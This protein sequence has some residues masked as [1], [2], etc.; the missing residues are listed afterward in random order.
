MVEV[1]ELI[2][3]VKMVEMAV[4]EELKVDIEDLLII[5]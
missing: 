4:V 5:L 2:G 3:M 1:K